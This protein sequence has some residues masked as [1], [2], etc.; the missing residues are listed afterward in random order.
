MNITPTLE[1]K[2]EKIM[3][4]SNAEKDAIRIIKEHGFQ[5]WE[6]IK[7]CNEIITLCRHP[8]QYTPPGGLVS[9]E[10]RLSSADY[11]RSVR[12]KIHWYFRKE[13]QEK[14]Y[15]LKDKMWVRAKFEDGVLAS[16]HEI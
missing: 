11:W 5:K 8:Q 13:N 12:K 6:A 9:I 15:Q 4:K 3:G 16:Q 2:E 1:E 14:L 10:Q 7:N